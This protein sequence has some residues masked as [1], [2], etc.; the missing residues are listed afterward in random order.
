MT[1]L[2]SI[3]FVVLAIVLSCLV[4]VVAWVLARPLLGPVARTMAGQLGRRLYRYATD[5]RDVAGPPQPPQP[6]Q[7]H[8]MA[9]PAQRPQAPPTPTDPPTEQVAAQVAND[10]TPV[11]PAAV[12]DTCVKVPPVIAPPPAASLRGLRGSAVDVVLIDNTVTIGRGADRD[13]QLDADTVSRHHCTLRFRADHWHLQDTGS[14]NGTYV[15]G[16]PVPNGKWVPLASGD[17]IGLGAD[18]LLMLTTSRVDNQDLVLAVGGATDK[19][20]R[21]RNE[22]ALFANESVVAVADG[23]GGRPGGDVASGIAVS[24]ARSASQGL[25]LAHL[26]PAMNA[27]IASRGQADTSLRDMATT[28]DGAQLI[29]ELGGTVVRGIHIGDGR[30]L[31]D[32][33]KHIKTLTVPHTLGGR[34]ASEGNPA[35]ARHP[36]RARLLRVLGTAAV[37]EFDQWEQ[38]AVVG[39]RYVL[40][41]DGV[42]NAMSE[43]ELHEALVQLRGVRPDAAAKILVDSV[44]QG[45]NA[46]RSKLDNLTVVIADVRQSVDNSQPIPVTLGKSGQRMPAIPR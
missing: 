14:P 41:T 13:I 35:A 34:L 8:P 42:L 33:G 45:S 43:D 12:E 15:N 3:V 11:V 39:H 44:L 6:W 40:S 2:L 17:R 25:T 36:D 10:S 19:G 18:V 31:L 22:D 4:L 16:T 37:P 38:R 9:P 24:L 30:V 21:E 28:F 29:T 7:Q 27:A 26:V 1:I 32:D 46:N 20:G 23:V 5:D